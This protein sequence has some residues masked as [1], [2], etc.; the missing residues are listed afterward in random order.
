MRDALSGL[1]FHESIGGVALGL[2]GWVGRGRA[3]QSGSGIDAGWVGRLGMGM[4]WR[5]LDSR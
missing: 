3:E 4:R 5:V 2:G 1:A